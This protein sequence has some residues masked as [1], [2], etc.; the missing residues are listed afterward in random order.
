LCAA[1]APAVQVKQYLATGS[2]KL[3]DEEDEVLLAGC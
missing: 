2:V 3:D 1:A